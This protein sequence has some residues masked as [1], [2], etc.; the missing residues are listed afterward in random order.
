MLRDDQRRVKVQ[1]EISPEYIGYFHQW[2]T[3]A[4]Q[5]EQNT[6]IQVTVAIVEK[7]DGKVE[8]VDPEHL[9]F[10]PSEREEWAE[11]MKDKLKGL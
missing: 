4:Y 8:L 7:K 6:D 10:M 1:S 9:T 2:G 11:N 3:R 5:G